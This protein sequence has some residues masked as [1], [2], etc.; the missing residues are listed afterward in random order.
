MIYLL[1]ADFQLTETEEIVIARGG[2]LSPVSTKK[3]NSI[4]AKTTPLRN[5]NKG[6]QIKF[7]SFRL[8]EAFLMTRKGERMSALKILSHNTISSGAGRGRNKSEEKH[9]ENIKFLST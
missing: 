1:F 5:K 9:I 7:N 4:P 8:A 6:S 2:G 3:V